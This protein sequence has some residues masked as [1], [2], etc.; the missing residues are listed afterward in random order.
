MNDKILYHSHELLID[1]SCA[2]GEFP[3][4]GIIGFS[5]RNGDTWVHFIYDGKKRSKKCFRLFNQLRISFNGF[6][7][8]VA[9]DPSP[10]P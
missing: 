5:N 8:P 10:A 2:R 3:N 7:F 1:T 4:L 9:I 6:Q